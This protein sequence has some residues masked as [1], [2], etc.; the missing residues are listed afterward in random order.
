METPQCPQD[1]PTFFAKAWNAGDAA[2]LGRLFVEDADF[3]NVVGLWWHNRSDIERA[4]E[5]GLKTFFKFAQLSVRRTKVRLLDENNAVIHVRWMLS[6]QL[7]KDGNTLDDRTAIM[8]FVAQRQEDRWAVV[9]AQ[10]TDV[11]PGKETLVAKA[12]RREAVDYKN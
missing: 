2:A 8:M 9:A 11:I 7:D 4:H 3:V 5:Y 12:G 10:N 6:G 1:I